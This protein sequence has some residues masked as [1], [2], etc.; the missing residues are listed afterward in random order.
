MHDAFILH[1]QFDPIAFSL[2]PL[3][4]HWYGICWAIAFFGAEFSV[5]H[6]LA[7]MGWRA[8]NVSGLV[9]WALAGTIIGARLAHCLFYDPAHYLSHP[10]D[11]LALWEGGMAS[12]GGAV[13]LIVALHWGMRR[14]APALPLLTL[15]DATTFSAAAGAALI[16]TANFLN[17]EIVGNPT[18]G[19]WG[20]VFDRVDALPRHPVQLY[21]A[22]AYL[23]VLLALRLAA[24]R[25]IAPHRP[26]YLTGLF[27]VMVFGAR[28]VIETWKTPQA[29]YEAGALFSVGQWLSLPFVLLGLALVIR[30][31]RRPGLPG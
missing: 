27:L 11:I 18:S 9:V 12:H 8:V 1:W 26:G 22:V 20:V 19:R 3:Q 21:E 7:S 4:V 2:G 24:R 23:F 17:S 10:L 15:L 29:V 16:R 6:R 25:Q 28:A 13:G 14:H 30:T 5:R 31:R